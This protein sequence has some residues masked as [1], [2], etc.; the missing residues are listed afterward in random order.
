MN[1]GIVGHEESKFTEAGMNS[2][3]RSIDY[4]C[5]MADSPRIVSGHCHLG[6]IDIWAENYAD[7]HGLPKLIF[8]PKNKSWATGYKPRNI[9]IA[10]HSDV[11]HI[12][13]V[14]KYPPGWTGM[15]FRL[16]YHCKSTNHIKSGGCWTGHYA[17]RFG[18]EVYWHVIPN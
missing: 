6:G 7:I 13:V 10:E 14:D 15:T 3:I 8:P 4:I 9:Q 17:R 16:C 18:K 11:V 1:I 5:K 2:A 12:I